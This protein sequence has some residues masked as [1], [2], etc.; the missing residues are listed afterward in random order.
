MKA[1]LRFLVLWTVLAGTV[2]LLLQPSS[3]RM[4]GLV[5]GVG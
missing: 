5:I 3:T 1:F 2:W 4:P